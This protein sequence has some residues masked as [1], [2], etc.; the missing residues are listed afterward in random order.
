MQTLQRTHMTAI[1]LLRDEALYI[2]FP[3]VWQLLSSEHA[4]LGTV[5]QAGPMVRRS[6]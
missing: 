1:L 3:T 4:S 2:P 6:L 5:I